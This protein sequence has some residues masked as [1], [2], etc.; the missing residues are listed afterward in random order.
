MNVNA[1][2][3]LAEAARY[4]DA[5]TAW[6][7][8]IHAH[9]EVGFDLPRTA[10]MVETLLKS[11][12]FQVQTGF[13]ASAVLGVWNTGRPGKTVAV[14]ADMDALGMQEQTDLPFRSQCDGACHACGHDAHTALLLGLAQ[15][16]S[17]HPEQF[18]GVIKLIFQPAEEGP[19][20]G[21]A[22]LIVDSGVLDGIDAIFGAH[23]QPLYKAGYMGCKYGDAF[24]SGD[25]FEVKLKG[26]GCHAASPHRGKDVICTA[27]QIIE[28]IQHIR[29]R[30]L[31]PL[32]A[33]VISVCSINAG[34]LETKN[35]LPSE[36]TFGGTFRAYD[37]EVRDYMAR[38]IEEVV[39]SICA[40]N[41]CEYEY[42]DTFA[43]PALVNDDEIIDT[44]Y[45]SAVEVLGPDKVIKKPD[46]EMG[47]EDFAQYTRKYKGAF[48]FFGIHNEDKQC[49]YSLH[50]PKFNLDEDAFG[51]TLAVYVNTLRH[52]LEQSVGE[53][54]A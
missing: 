33:G 24:A 8:E 7:R 20:P 32:K 38:R 18:C 44:I 5:I 31:P 25:F 34:K 48:F 1:A 52:L 35:V 6:R 16:I 41:G 49:T 37:D 2:A 30:E 42:T 40:L 17:D 19:A 21:G 29:S 14:R 51:P 15:Y 22:K 39:R 23:S 4:Q 28:A 50:N 36:L 43:Y 11:F 53:S 47:S 13:A 26:A 9:P 54:D 10:G 45:R 46:P 3:I 27:L 12:G